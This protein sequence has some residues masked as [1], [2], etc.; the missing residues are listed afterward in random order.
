MNSDKQPA[1]L[2]LT[3]GSGEQAKLRSVV[4]D[5]QDVEELNLTDTRTIISWVLSSRSI[6]ESGR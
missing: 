4:N 2:K 5:Q 1:G 6:V 3:S